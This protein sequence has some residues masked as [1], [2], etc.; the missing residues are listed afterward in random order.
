MPY[1]QANHHHGLKFHQRAWRQLPT[2]RNQVLHAVESDLLPA[3]FGLWYGPSNLDHWHRHEARLLVV[4]IVRESGSVVVV[5]LNSSSDE[6]KVESRIA[7]RKLSIRPYME[8]GASVYH[9]PLSRWTD[10]DRP[11]IIVPRRGNVTSKESV[12]LL[13]AVAD[14]I[15]AMASQVCLLIIPPIFTASSSAIHDQFA[16]YDQSVQR[17]VVLKQTCARLPCG[18]H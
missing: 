16:T 11:M 1:P 12:S 14:K 18:Y 2:T 8:S 3:H 9:G 15:Q 7:S 17:V 4:K 5:G 13:T 6:T 10:F